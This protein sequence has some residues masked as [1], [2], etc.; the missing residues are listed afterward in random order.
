[1]CWDGQMTVLDLLQPDLVPGRL[2]N[3]GFR[4]ADAEG[5]MS[6]VASFDDADWDLAEQDFGR[7]RENV[8]NVAGRLN[9]VP[10]PVVDHPAGTDA[11]LLAALVAVA[12]DVVAELR[13]RGLDEESAWRSASD[14]GQQVHIH[15]LVHGRFGFGARS[16]TPVNFSGSL[17]WLGRL[18]Y[19]LEHDAALGWNLGCHIPES[20]PLTPEL[21]DSSLALARSVAT[22][23][24]AE[25]PVTAFTCTSWLLDPELVARLDPASNMA[26]FAGRFTPYGER[27]PGLRDAL[28]FG[29]HKEVRGGAEVD[30]ASLPG[31][32]ALRRALI[33][34]LSS[35][36]G[37]AVCSGWFRL[38]WD[39]P[40]RTAGAG[41]C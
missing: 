19:T 1:M 41:M 24:W 31:D 17:L 28:F 26:A 9:P 7:L 29:F 36:E 30:P 40:S 22:A 11:P 3:L 21:V 5:F 10:G 8:G 14:L 39:A 32:S 4:D 15:R 16:W 34:Q 27:S 33:A 20:G 6:A 18:Q 2:G 25:F 13:R 35:P 12:P 37:A 38:A 23:V